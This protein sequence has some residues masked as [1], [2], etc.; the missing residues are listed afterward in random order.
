MS[1]PDPEIERV[2]NLIRDAIEATG[3]RF[4]IWNSEWAC[5]GSFYEIAQALLEAGW[6]PPE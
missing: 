3:E 2:A 6:K 1:E 5:E 4:S